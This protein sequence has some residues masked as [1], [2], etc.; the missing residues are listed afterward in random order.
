MYR[1]PDNMIESIIILLLLLTVYLII[2]LV[3]LEI[4]KSIFV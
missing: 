3:V 1:D 2:P 4:F